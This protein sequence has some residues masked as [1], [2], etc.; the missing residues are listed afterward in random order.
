MEVEIG[1]GTSR[2][3]RVVSMAA[4]VSANHGTPAPGRPAADVQHQAHAEALRCAPARRSTAR[5]GGSMRPAVWMP[6]FAARKPPLPG[7]RDVRIPP[8]LMNNKQ[9]HEME[10]W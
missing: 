9:N 10:L 5:I 8:A 6:T 7:L 2:Q 4:P 1:N 3:G